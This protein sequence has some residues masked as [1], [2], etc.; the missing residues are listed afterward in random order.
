MKSGQNLPPSHSEPSKNEPLNPV[1]RRRFMQYAAGVGAVVSLG[2]AIPSWSQQA[3]AGPALTNAGGSSDDRL[4]DGTQHVSWEQPLTF[5]KT[6]Y[7]DNNHAKA[8]DN[9]PGTSAKPFRTINKAAQVLQ[10]G[11]RVVIA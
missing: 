11:E 8:D 6:Y 5:T 9:G 2:G 1:N 3:A 4:P 10:P 7:V